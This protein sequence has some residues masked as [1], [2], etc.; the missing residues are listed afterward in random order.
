MLM[1]MTNE[2]FMSFGFIMCHEI[3]SLFAQSNIFIGNFNFD[4]VFLDE[5]TVNSNNGNFIAWFYPVKFMGLS[6]K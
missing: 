1:P 3:V 2:F 6:Q 5:F 4:Q